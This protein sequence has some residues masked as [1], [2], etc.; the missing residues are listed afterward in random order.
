MVI[1]KFDFL[2]ASSFRHYII[3]NI[4]NYEKEHIRKS[5]VAL[6]IFKGAFLDRQIHAKIHTVIL[7]EKEIRTALRNH[8][9]IIITLLKCEI[10]KK[11]SRADLISIPSQFFNQKVF[12][13]CR[14]SVSIVE[15]VER[16]SLHRVEVIQGYFLSL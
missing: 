11:I 6:C 4:E 2:V 8:L 14:S 7:I 13:Y 16:G 9:P 3:A 15:L 12:R 5:Y 10:W 1:G